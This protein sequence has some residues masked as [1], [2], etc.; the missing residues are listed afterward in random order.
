M[1]TDPS[2]EAILG[3]QAVSDKRVS[4]SGGCVNRQIS[5]TRKHDP[6]NQRDEITEKLC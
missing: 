5:R 6:E 2:T 4:K 3:Q 1:R